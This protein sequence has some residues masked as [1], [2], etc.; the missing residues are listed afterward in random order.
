MFAWIIAGGIV[1]IVILLMCIPMAIRSELIWHELS[2]HGKLHFSLVGIPVFRMRAVAALDPLGFSM[3]YR[4]SFLAEK[5]IHFKWGTKQDRQNKIKWRGLI[6]DFRCKELI[7]AFDL[8]IPD[9]AAATAICYGTLNSLSHLLVCWAKQRGAKEC[10]AQVNASFTQAMYQGKINCIFQT[11][12]GHII[13][14][15][16]KI[17]RDKS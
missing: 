11:S 16:Y 7:I 5:A 6:Q 13:F 2:L 3:H 17:W 12:L 14:D 8:G 9:N 4:W 1:I 10:C 15:G